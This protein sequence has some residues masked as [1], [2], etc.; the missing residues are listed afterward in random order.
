MAKGIVNLF[1]NEP[2]LCTK[3]DSSHSFG[4]TRKGTFARSLCFNP[5]EFDGINCGEFAIIGMGAIGQPEFQTPRIREVWISHR[6]CVMAEKIS[7]NQ[8]VQKA[9]EEKVA[10]AIHSKQ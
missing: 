2:S 6:K 7:L 1:G 3:A 9:L 4:M 8:L 10:V 5:I